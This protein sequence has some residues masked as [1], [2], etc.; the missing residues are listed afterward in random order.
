VLKAISRATFDLQPV[1]D[2]LVTT[3]ARLCEA[4]NAFLLDREGD[5]FRAKAIFQMSPDQA[6]ILQILTL[7]MDRGTISGRVALEGRVV[8]IADV[9]RD[10][11]SVCPSRTISS[12]INIEARLRWRARSDRSPNSL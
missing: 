7:K 9:T 11:D 1:L 5:T 2:T 3:A 10:P 6:A 8:Q 4:E 12:R